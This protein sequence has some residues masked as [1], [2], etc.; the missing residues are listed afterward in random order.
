MNPLFG[1]PGIAST[2][3]V[4]RRKKG[5]PKS[6]GSK[7]IIAGGH[8]VRQPKGLA[9]M[10][11]SDKELLTR[12]TTLHRY[13]MPYKGEQR[14]ELFIH[15]FY[16]DRKVDQLSRCEIFHLNMLQY[17]NVL[18]RVKVIHV[19]CASPNLSPTAAMLCAIEILSAGKA[20]VDFKCVLPKPGWEH[21]TFKECVEYAVST[22]EF[23]Y[24]THFKGVTRIP[25]L[26]SSGRLP[27]DTSVLDEYYWCYVMYH[28]LFTAPIGVKAIGPVRT[29]NHRLL[30]VFSD[31]SWTRLVKDG[32][33]F[34]YRGSFQ[35]FSGRYLEGCFTE[36][37]AG[38]ALERERLFWFGHTHMVELFL[39]AVCREADIWSL[40]PDNKTMNTP[41]YHGFAKRLFPSLLNSFKHLGEDSVPVIASMTSWKAR[42]DNV[43]AVVESL[44]GQSRPLDAIELNLSLEEFPDQM[45]SLPDSILQLVAD[46]KLIV[47][48]V[49]EDSGPFKK[50]IPTLQKH[51]GEDYVLLSV[52]DD[53]LYGPQYVQLMLCLLAGHDVACADVGYVGFKAALRS[54]A[55]G[56]ELWNLLTP[57]VVSL[58]VDD[59]Y[60]A[61]YLAR[62]RV[63]CHYES[64]PE[65]LSQLSDYNPV[66]PNSS[67]ADGY[68]RTH[69]EA[70]H[71]AAG[72]ALKGL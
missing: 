72:E 56:P 43:P 15:W 34:F 33:D 11:A 67:M 65:I 69:I 44:L 8:L 32:Q 58:R 62:K 10:S 14:G 40:P 18:D 60:V 52:D 13:R 19:R 35:A 46:H 51:L 42:I 2:G 50:I 21:D 37:G 59:T 29:N 57:R 6:S 71:V 22:G 31:P 66:C 27:Q 9:P 12:L 5:K 47:N 63:D 4:S 30:A 49:K 26:G 61:E 53:I 3:A 1:L 23:V 38:S 64:C 70:A 28:C 20:V 25:D 45:E 16:R 68:S 17:F 48:W 39:S 36:L 7:L 55:V 54:H 24:Y 41:G